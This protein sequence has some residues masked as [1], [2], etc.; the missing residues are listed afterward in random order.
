[1]IPIAWVMMV[2]ACWAIASQIVMNTPY[3][4]KH[5]ATRQKGALVII[6]A[7]AFVAWDLFL[8]PQMTSWRF[9]EWYYS[10]G[11]YF[12]IPWSN[13]GGWA[14][15]MGIITALLLPEPTPQ[16]SLILIYGLTWGLESIA[17]LFFWNLSGPA[18]CGFFGMGLFVYL[19]W[20]FRQRSVP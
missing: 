5:S 11:G 1:M 17:L 9:W 18:V 20:H 19:A 7:L 10:P 13:F 12:G 15:S 16:P 4:Q 8:D 6:S 2:P 14:L 3:S